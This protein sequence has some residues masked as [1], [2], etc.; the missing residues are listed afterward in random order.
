MDIKQA[1]HQL[2][3]AQGDPQALTI[4]TARIVC[5]RSHPKLFEILEAAAI[6]HWFNARNTCHPAANRYRHGRRLAGEGDSTP[7]GG[8]LLRTTSLERA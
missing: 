1:L 4:T 2:E 5:S 7:H 6:P 3:Q 8:N